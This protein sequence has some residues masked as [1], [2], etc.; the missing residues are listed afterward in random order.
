M[1]GAAVIGLGVGRQHIL[2]Y[3][4]TGRAEV[5]VIC[6]LQEERLQRVGEE[7]GIADRVTD[8]REVAAR[9]DVQVVSI[10]TPDHLHTEPAL[11]MM[12]AGKHVLIEKPLATTWEDVRRLVETAHRT[13]V[14]VAHGCQLRYLPLYQELKRHIER[15]ELGE[16]FYAEGDYIGSHLELLTEGWRGQL[17]AAYNGVAGG[18][19]HPLDLLCWLI[20]DRVVEVTAYGNKKCVE[21]FGFEVYDCIVAILKFQQGAIAKSLTTL[22]AARPGFRYLALYGTRGTYLNT[23]YPAQ[24]LI[25]TE[26]TQ[27]QWQSL[28]VPPAETE[29]RVALIQ[30][31]LDAIERDT[32]PLVNL[33]EAAQVAAVCIAAFESV[34]QGRPVLVPDR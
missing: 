16:L 7:L 12:E 30:D 5:R 26:T 33:A 19:V 29:P 4:A 27:Q 13:G 23:P 31:L 15:G 32:Q 18:G 11:A 22:A 14:K 20:G 25:V 3:R 21:P 17:G 2:D 6:D 10:C 1:F 8:F 9:D 24:N 28:T 34:Q